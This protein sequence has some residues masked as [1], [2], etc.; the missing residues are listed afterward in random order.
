MA[1]HPGVHCL[2]SNIL[3]WDAER[4][5]RTCMTLTE[6]ESVFR[7]LKSELGLRPVYHQKPHRADGHLLADLSAGLSGG[8]RAAH[9]HASPSLP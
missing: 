1:T 3:D 4:M 2:R 8:V 9:P 6:V 5:W 7:A